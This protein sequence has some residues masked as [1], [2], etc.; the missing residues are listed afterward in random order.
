MIKSK[1]GNK[2][3]NNHVVYVKLPLY[4][5]Q[6]LVHLYGDADGNIKFPECSNIYTCMVL[7]LRQERNLV[8]S[9]NAELS[10][11]VISISKAL[12]MFLSNK[13]KLK[14]N[15]F[16]RFVTPKVVYK[17]GKAVPVNIFFSV[18]R[19]TCQLMRKFCSAFFW[20]KFSVFVK[21]QICSS[22]EK[23]NG[24]FAFVRCLEDFM[25][26]YGI[27]DS[28]FDVLQRNYTRRKDDFG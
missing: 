16:F 7:G 12:Y 25:C 10:P 18:D 4:V 20:K 23:G 1:S 22:Q 8:L 11:D 26:K 3:C 24:I 28:Q 14:A 5:G 27:E 15:N 13:K 17:E 19:D 2:H 6:F 21:E 9:D